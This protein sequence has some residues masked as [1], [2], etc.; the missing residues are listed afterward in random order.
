MGPR[1]SSILPDEKMK[2]FEGSSTRAPWLVDG[3]L[4]L[5]AELCN[6]DSPKDEEDEEDEEEVRVRYGGG[7][8]ANSTS[9][10][11]GSGTVE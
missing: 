7:L 6:D 2:C 4:E 10:S 5:A 1:S 9:S 8:S 3:R 11:H